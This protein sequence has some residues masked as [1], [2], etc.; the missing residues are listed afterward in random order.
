MSEC[1][2]DS[3][4]EFLQKGVENGRRRASARARQPAH[5]G[6]H[7]AMTRP[8]GEFQGVAEVRH[9]PLFRPFAVFPNRLAQLA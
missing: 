1:P 7:G 4:S 6:C 2:L 8:A 3:T 5:G 9:R